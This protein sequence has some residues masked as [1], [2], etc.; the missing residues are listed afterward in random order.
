MQKR[1]LKEEN[2]MKC[3]NCGKEWNGKTVMIWIKGEEYKCAKEKDC[4]K[5]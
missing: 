3:I 5:R 4:K 2:K 1:I